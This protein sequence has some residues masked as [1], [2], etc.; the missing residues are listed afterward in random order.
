MKLKTKVLPEY[1]CSNCAW[2]LKGADK[3]TIDEAGNLTI[4]ECDNVSHP[5]EDCVL[6]G[7]GCHSEQPT[8]IN[9]I[10]KEITI[11]DLIKKKLGIK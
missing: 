7:F 8:F 5:L 6:N 2:A 11:F 3:F 1:N 9:T 4:K 10:N